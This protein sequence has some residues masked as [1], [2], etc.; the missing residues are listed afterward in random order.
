MGYFTANPT[1]LVLHFSD[2]YV[3][4]Y[5]IYKNQEITFTIGVHLL[6]QGP[7]KECWLC[8]VV[9]GR[10]GRRGLGKFRRCIARVRPGGQGRVLRFTGARFRGLDGAEAAPAVGYTGSQWRR[11][12]RLAMPATRTSGCGLQVGGELLWS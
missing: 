8:N 1:K 11:P 9:P 4:C 6:Q 3:I 12:P 5:A 2:F 10:S 7:W